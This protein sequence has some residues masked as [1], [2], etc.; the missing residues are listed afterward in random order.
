MRLIAFLDRL[1]GVRRVPSGHMARCPAHDD[2]QASLSVSEGD[3]GR[4]L[5]R[6]HAGCETEAIVSAVGSRMSDLFPD[7]RPAPPPRRGATI[8]AVY[9]YRDETNALR[10]QVVRL[11]PKGFRQRRPDGGGGW[12]WSLAGVRRVVYRL[13]ELVA[14]DPNAPVWIVEGEKDADRLARL[15]LVA[16][17]NPGGAGK[18]RF[19][20]ADAGRV[21][22]GRA[23]IL[24]PDNDDP[25]RKHAAEVAAALRDHA[26][27]VRILELPGLPPKGDVSTWLDAGGTVEELLRLARDAPEARAEGA[28][29]SPGTGCTDLANAER[30]VRHHRERVRYLPQRDAWLLWDGR[31]WKVDERGDVD[32]LADLTARSI[33]AEAAAAPVAAERTRLATWAIASESAAR[34]TALVRRARHQPGIAVLQAELDRD[35]YRL[36]VVNGTLDLRTG[37][38]GPHRREELI[39]R[40]APVA[41]DPDATCPTWRAFLERVLPAEGLRVFLQRAVGYS[42]TGDTREHCFL[43]CYG[44]G[45]NGKSTLLETIQALAGDYGRTAAATTFVAKQTDSVRNDLAMLDGARFV[46]ASETESGRRLDEAFIKQVTG[47][48]S[49]TARFLY[50]EYF[51][52]KPQFKVWLAS[53][54]KPVVRGVDDGIWRRIRFVPF[55]V[56]IPPEERDKDLPAKLRAELPGILAWAVRGCL[57]WQREGLGDPPEVREATAEYREEM[58]PIGGFLEE[59]CVLDDREQIVSKEL[60]A[61]YVEWC[62]GAEERPL[63]SRAFGRCLAARGL[64][65]V[66]LGHAV[67]RGWRGI[68]LCSADVCRRQQTSVSGNSILSTYTI[69][70]PETK[71]QLRKASRRSARMRAVAAPASVP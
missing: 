11:E 64:Q 48:D 59:R 3:D 1:D 69:E 5:L 27:S 20:A 32:Q 22:A 63:S 16:T 43:L 23:V 66:R 49:V 21:L 53:N 39:T 40:L 42:L 57:D 12:T 6:C 15:G 38:L 4:I 41:Y 62:Q 67:A 18:W 56:T 68:S 14:A 31:R 61:A 2:R 54:Y 30:F 9:D 46:A 45:A 29:P 10:F 58:D 28:A 71:R 65:P 70:V 55:D 37:D 7:A 35:P 17:T 51:T 60:Y 8:A 34:L 13:P 36:N 44:T 47:G 19:V 52:F 50:G 25:G 24:L 33:Y 26:R